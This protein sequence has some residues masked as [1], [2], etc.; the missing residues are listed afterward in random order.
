MEYVTLTTKEEF[1]K[2]LQ[3]NLGA[4]VYFSSFTCNVGEALEPKVLEMLQTDYPKIPFFY[5]DMKASP[6]IAAGNNVFVEPTVLVFF[7]GKETIR[8]SR[9][10]SIPDLSQSIE[11]IYKIAF[12]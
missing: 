8:K 6:D 10:I 7:D 1:D 3:D 9:H 4:L 11:R 2:A 12:D 5:V